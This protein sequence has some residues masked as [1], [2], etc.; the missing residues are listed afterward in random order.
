MTDNEGRAMPGPLPRELKVQLA[1]AIAAGAAIDRWA[2]SVSVNVRTARR[3]ARSDPVKRRVAEIRRRV[4][5][6]TVGHLSEGARDAA[7][8]LRVLIQQSESEG[9][10]LSA[11]RTILDKLIEI[12]NHAALAERIAALEARLESIHEQQPV[13]T[14]GRHRAAPAG[15]SPTDPP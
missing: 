12:E 7:L 11:A 6:E 5:E 15:W 13:P 9:V 2:K 14:P 8:T 4:L 3:W 10:K 1:Q